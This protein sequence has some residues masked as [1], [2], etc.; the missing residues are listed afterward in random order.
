MIDNR[1]L[2]RQL[3]ATKGIR[4]QGSPLF[5]V[6]PPPLPDDVSWDRVEAMMLGTG[7]CLALT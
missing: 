4:L 1:E 6:V 7:S 5:E 3:F 2:L